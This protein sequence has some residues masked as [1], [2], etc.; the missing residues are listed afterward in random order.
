MLKMSNPCMCRDSQHAY[1]FFHHCCFLMQVLPSV[2]CDQSMLQTADCPQQLL[3][4]WGQISH[5]ASA[6]DMTQL[7]GPVCHKFSKMDAEA[8]R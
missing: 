2:E 7:A 4:S 3:F 8:S 5:I 6:S 1:S